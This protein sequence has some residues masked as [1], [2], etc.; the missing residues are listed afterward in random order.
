MSYPVTVPHGTN[1]THWFPNAMKNAWVKHKPDMSG[2]KEYNL[3]DCWALEY[4]NTAELDDTG[5]WVVLFPTEQD[6][7]MFLLR[8]L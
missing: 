4:D 1:A 6:Y 5:R 8:W 7:V 2:K 3:S